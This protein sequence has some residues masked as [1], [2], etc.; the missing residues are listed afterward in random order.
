MSEVL[1]WAL[2]TMVIFAVGLPSAI[3]FDK[4]KKEMDEDGEE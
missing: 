2:A 1:G 3:L 4:W